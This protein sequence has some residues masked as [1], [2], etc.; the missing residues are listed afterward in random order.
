MT[1]QQLPSKR[2][3]LKG[4]IQVPG[5]KSISHRAIMLGSMARG[6]SKVR[7]LLMADDVQSTM[8]VYRQLGV[9]IETSGE[10]TVIVSPGVAH[11][12]A[13]DQPLDFG[14]SGT[15]LRLSLGVLAKQ[16]F[17]IDMIGDASL[18]KRPMGRVLKPLEK[19]GLR[20]VTPATGLPIQLA[21]NQTLHGIT[22]TLPVAS[23][24][25]KS[26]LILA[27]L[28]ADQMTRIT[29]PIATRDH[30]E[31]MLTTFGV[32]LKRQDNT[33]LVPA[34]QSLS[35][36]NVTVPGDFSSA[37]FWLVAGVLVPDSQL[38][39]SEIGLNPTRTGL[40]QL[41]KRMGAEI[42]VQM[43]QTSGEP[44]GDV[45]VQTQ[46]LRG[47]DV[48][49]NDIPA[50]IDELPLLVLAA[51]QAEGV[52][53]ITGAEELRVKE[54]DRIDAVTT[55]LNRLGAQVT[56]LP[57]GFSIN[58][59]TPLHVAEPTVVRSHGD[60]R[61]G[62][63]LAIAALL[64]EGALTLDGAESVAISYPTFFNDLAQL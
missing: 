42:P 36:A 38:A 16:P 40:I 60:H 45:L 52:T 47:I 56:A 12:R 9:T 44:I 5:D 39:L 37:A 64:T 43:H 24:Q 8:Q 13:P 25:V 58:G 23:A 48:T 17:H 51:T 20:P 19:M 54:T 18:Q 1:Q 53:T 57:D 15:T 29:E 26:A 59:P 55:E 6:T 31:R 27:G 34:A 33:L 46:S 32:T 61:I 49:K 14:N 10:D 41:L 22:Y 11:L 3:H 62:M 2:S 35:P 30:T 50:V 7:H 4:M 28:Q 63:M 21:P